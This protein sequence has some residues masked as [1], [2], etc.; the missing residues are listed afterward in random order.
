MSESKELAVLSAPLNPLVV[1]GAGGVDDIP[2][3]PGL[4]RR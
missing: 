4:L 3:L 2:D 1:F